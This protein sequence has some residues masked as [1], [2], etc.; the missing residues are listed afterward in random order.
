MTTRVFLI[1]DVTTKPG[2]GQAFLDAYL[3][4]Y[5]PGAR[6]RGMTLVHQ[7]VEPAFWLLDRPN[8]LL[9]IW[10]IDAPPGVWAAKHAARHDPTIRDWWNHH[11]APLVASRRRSIVADAADL[12]V[13]ADV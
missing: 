12:E 5:A 11:A 13:L 9:F 10:S 1:D 7:L 3:S 2:R 8:R 4:E 6:E